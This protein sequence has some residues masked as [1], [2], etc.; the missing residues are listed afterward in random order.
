M[1]PIA[2]GSQRELFVDP[3]LIDTLEGA[4]QHLHEPVRKETVFRVVEPLENACTGCYNVVQADGR[5]MVFYRGYHP[6]GHDLPEGWQETQTANLLYSDDGIH[7]E[8]PELGLVEAEGSTANNILLRGA[9]SHNL[10]AFRDDNPDAAPEQRFKA[11]GGEGRNRLWGFASP[12]GL[13]WKPVQDG[14]LAITGAFDS[15][16]VPLWDGYTGCYRIFSRYFEV[17]EAGER[18]R[19]IQSCTSDDFMHWTEPVP[20]VYG[21]GVPL[22]H[23]YTNATTPCP[24]AEH[25]LLSFPMRFVPKRTKDTTGMDYPGDG[26]SDAVF[27][28]S[29]D[30]VHWDRTFMDAWLRPGLDQRNWT[31]RNQTPA[32]GIFPTA[33]DEWSMYVSE[34]YGWDTNAMRRV[35]VRPHGFAS[36]RA[37]YHGGELRTKPLTFSGSTLFINYSTSA[38][39]SVSV[40]IQNAEGRPLDGFAA[41][42]MDPLFGDALDAPVAWKGGGSP[43]DLSRLSNL[44][45]TPVRLHFV[46]KDADLFSIRFGDS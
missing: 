6:V 14:P 28:T 31:H 43:G 22:E 46:L 13:V 9:Q 12:D 29:R 18:I 45:G 33:P 17:D 3:Y 25:I 1:T 27:M 20:H 24:G 5:I 4:Y 19:A 39:G 23:F 38:V 21:E 8:R 41:G 40:E 34:H 30:G 44:Y 37:G 26:V 35:T 16:N 32:A 36:V 42:D 11:V 10:C 15:V 2:L 7:F